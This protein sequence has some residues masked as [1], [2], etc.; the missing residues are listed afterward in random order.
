MNGLSNV[1]SVFQTA[2]ATISRAS[3]AAEQ[4]AAVVANATMAGS[5]ASG[6]LTVGSPDFL[7]AMI[8]ARQQTLYT[9]AAARMISTSNQMIGS[10]L[11]V[12]A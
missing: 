5:G 12:T 4:D 7:N 2:A 8:D 3:A 11:D 6:G 10:L 9:A 1:G